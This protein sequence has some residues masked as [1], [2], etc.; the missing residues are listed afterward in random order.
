VTTTETGMWSGCRAPNLL[1]KI[2]DGPPMKIID[3]PSDQQK[4]TGG[5]YRD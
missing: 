3:R 1:P 2:S 5:R 4:H